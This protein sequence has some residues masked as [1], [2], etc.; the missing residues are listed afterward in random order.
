MLRVGSAEM[1]T[2][3]NE[4]AGEMREMGGGGARRDRRSSRT[5][6][7]YPR[8]AGIDFDWKSARIVQ[9]SR[10]T[11]SR[12]FALYTFVSGSLVDRYRD[13]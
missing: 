6:R 4:D 12:F 3:R 2:E 8:S 1:L 5:R 9:R 11:E 10:G 13:K 7:R